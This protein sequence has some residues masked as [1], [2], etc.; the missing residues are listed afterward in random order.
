M[1]A[2]EMPGSQLRFGVDPASI[3]IGKDGVVN[4]VVVASSSSGAVNG[5]YEGVRCATGE[6]KLYA[7]N[8]PGSGW[9]PAKE[10]EWRPLHSQGMSR[11]SLLIA[12]NGACVGQAPNQS[13]S[14]IARDLQ[15]NPEYRFRP[16]I[17]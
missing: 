14:Q 7:R 17:R 2:L 9:V 16:E 5:M 13:P 11:H 1:V 3:Q 10:A 4:Y 15:G 8:L 12:R 6:M